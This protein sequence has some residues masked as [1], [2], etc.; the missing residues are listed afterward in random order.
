MQD[1]MV[2]GWRMRSRFHEAMI[3]LCDWQEGFTAS[4]L[5][6]LVGYNPSAMLEKWTAQQLIVR[7]RMGGRGEGYVY[8]FK[9][10]SK[11]LRKLY[12]A[13]KK[14]QQKMYKAYISGQHQED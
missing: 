14:E 7:L 13:W 2:K 3:Y 1:G 4:Q 8:Q 5:K 9:A 6:A 10:S 12:K 11:D